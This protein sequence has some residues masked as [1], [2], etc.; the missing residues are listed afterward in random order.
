MFGGGCDF[1]FFKLMLVILDYFRKEVKCIDFMEREGVEVYER[2][3]KSLI[4]INFE[5]IIRKFL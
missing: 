3:W 5:L 1:M 2:I 4:L